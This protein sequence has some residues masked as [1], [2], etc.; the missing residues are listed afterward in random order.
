MQPAKNKGYH[1][2]AFEFYKAILEKLDQQ[3]Y[4]TGLSYTQDITNQLRPNP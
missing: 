2:Y 4:V 1:K 3:Y